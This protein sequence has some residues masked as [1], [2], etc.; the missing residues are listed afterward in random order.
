MNET[1]KRNEAGYYEEYEPAF[2]Y[3]LEDTGRIE[4]DE[5]DYLFYCERSEGLISCGF[6]IPLPESEAS[7]IADFLLAFAEG[8]GLS[9][10]QTREWL[11]ADALK[12]IRRVNSSNG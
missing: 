3:V 9:P 7:E 11:T 10:S 2:G 5:L 8:E 1:I 12:W 4:F 6:L